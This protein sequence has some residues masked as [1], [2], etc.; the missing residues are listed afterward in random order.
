MREVSDELR[1]EACDILHFNLYL[2]D[3]I[4]LPLIANMVLQIY[5]FINCNVYSRA[6]RPI[7]SSSCKP[8]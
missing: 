4:V 2:L 8:K 6:L 3:W 7:S 1:G 5:L